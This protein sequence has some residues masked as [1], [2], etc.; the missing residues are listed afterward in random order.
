MKLLENAIQEPFMT[1][2]EHR[3]WGYYG[4]YADNIKCTTKILYIRRSGSLSL[5][6]HFRRDQEYLILDNDFTIFSSGFCST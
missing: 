3:P 2:V 1:V 4:L 5:Q 6:Y